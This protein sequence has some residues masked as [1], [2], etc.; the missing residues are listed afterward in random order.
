MK[1][2]KCEVYETEP[3]DKSFVSI[4]C[5]VYAGYQLCNKS[6]TVTEHH[7]QWHEQ[8]VLNVRT[9]RPCLGFNSITDF[10]HAICNVTGDFMIIATALY[11]Y[12]PSC[13][14]TE[15]H[16]TWKDI[17]FTG[18]IFW[19]VTAYTRKDNTTGKWDYNGKAYIV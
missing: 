4:H 6:V 13:Q 8:N 2:L 11:K 5:H 1:D 7:N 3:M 9:F 14:C 19:T 10:T 12:C 15:T 17:A 18:E 16:Y